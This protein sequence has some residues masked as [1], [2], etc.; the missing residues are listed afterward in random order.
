MDMIL[1][2]AEDIAAEYADEKALPEDWDWKGLA[3]AVFKQFNF[4]SAGRSMPIP[5]MA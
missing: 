4:P 5:S 2:K 1:E 3:D